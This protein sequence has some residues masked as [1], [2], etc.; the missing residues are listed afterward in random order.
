MTVLDHDLGNFQSFAVIETCPAHTLAAGSPGENGRGP[1]GRWHSPG[2]YHSYAWQL[3]CMRVLRDRRQEYLDAKATLTGLALQM[4]L[5]ALDEA[6]IAYRATMLERLATGNPLYASRPAA[7]LIAA[8]NAAVNKPPDN[9]P[10]WPYAMPVDP[11]EPPERLPTQAQKDAVVN[12]IRDV[13]Q[14]GRKMDGAFQIATALE[15]YDRDLATWRFLDTERVANTD[16]RI[17]EITLSGLNAAQK[18][19]V[20]NAIAI[21]FGSTIRVL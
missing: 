7:D 13:Q 3:G 11:P 17:L 16:E 1:D 8:L 4:R 6:T 14:E 18:A 19:R 10:D 5:H 9:D 20:A 2:E 12:H 15:G 21:Q